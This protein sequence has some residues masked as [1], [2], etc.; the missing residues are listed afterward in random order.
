MGNLG[1]LEV[2]LLW[3]NCF[4]CIAS[5]DDQSWACSFYQHTIKVRVTYTGNELA[6]SSMLLFLWPDVCK[7]RIQVRRGGVDYCQLLSS[8]RKSLLSKHAGCVP[9]TAVFTAVCLGLYYFLF[10]L[11]SVLLRVMFCFCFCFFQL[12]YFF[13]TYNCQ[14]QKGNAYHVWKIARPYH[15]MLEG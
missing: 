8:Q 7:P 6:S 14:T 1:V 5:V 4:N 12:G 9:S 10:S 2:R 15:T 11:Y 3:S 13:L